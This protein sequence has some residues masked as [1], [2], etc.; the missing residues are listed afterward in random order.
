MRPSRASNQRPGGEPASGSPPTLRRLGL[1]LA[2]LALLDGIALLFGYRLAAD[3][4]VVAA[5]ALLIVTALTNWIFLA[6][7][8]YPIRWLTPGLLLT[9]LL[10]VYPLVYTMYIAFTNYGDGH[11]LSKEQAIAQFE[12]RMFAPVDGPSY[13]WTA[14]ERPDG[15]YLVLLNDASGVPLLAEPDKPLT[16]VDPDDPRFGAA[17][18]DGLP[19]AIGDARRLSRIESVSRLNELTALEIVAGEATVRIVSL[20]AAM[21]QQQRYLYD[22]AHDTLT[23]V[24]DGTVYRA[25]EGTFTAEDGRRLAPGFAE[26]IG[27]RNFVRAFTDP[28]IRGPFLGVFAWTLV[29]AALSVFLTFTVG[30]GLALVLNDQSLPLKGALR[31]LAIVPYTIPGFISALIWVGLLN[32]FYGP[33]NQALEG[34]FGISPSWFSDPTLAKVAI[35]LVNTWLGYAYM[36]LICLGALQSIPSELFEAAIIDGASRLQQ[37]RTI[38]LPLL[39]ISVAPLLIGSFAFNFNNFAVIELVTQGGPPSPGTSTPAG[40]TDILISYTYRLAFAGGRGTDYGFA[41]AISL[42]I[43][44]IVATITAFNFRFTR[45]LEAISENV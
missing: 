14:Y 45:R 30:L 31:S 35:L 44:L 11:L 15:T 37:F 19:S 23:D 10:V 12:S 26:L 41:A 9:L 18:D 2:G 3:G 43:F 13:S 4:L 32:P 1:T 28:S 6:D 34:V 40:Q 24:Q 8:L 22:P 16:P 38:T 36:L 39:L 42:F 5:V 20:D 27:P 25:V 21:V 33:I 17:D 7:R 29:F